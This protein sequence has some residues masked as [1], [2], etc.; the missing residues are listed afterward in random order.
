MLVIIANIV[1]TSDKV[2]S[3]VA[4]KPQSETMDAQEDVVPAELPEHQEDI[5]MDADELVHAVCHVLTAPSYPVQARRDLHNSITAQEKQNAYAK[6]A[7]KDWTF[8]VKRTSIKIGRPP[9]A[10]YPET[11]QGLAQVTPAESNQGLDIPPSATED[12]RVHIDLGPNKVI[13]RLHA[14]IYYQ[15]DHI[16]QQPPGWYLLVNGRNGAKVD[17]TPVRR[18][19]VARLN[20]GC[21]IDIAGLEFMFVLSEGVTIAKPYLQRAG[22]I[23]NDFPDNVDQAR[24]DELLGRPTRSELGN[25]DR[26]LQQAGRQ[27][28]APA[29]ADYRKPDTPQSRQKPARMPSCTPR[30]SGYAFAD[31]DFDLSAP[32]NE[33]IKPTFTYSQLITQ[34][35]LSKPDHKATLF[36]IYEY[37]KAKYAYYRSGERAE[38]GWQVSCSSPC[39]TYNLLT[40]PEFYP[41]QPLS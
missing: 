32:E 3:K 1:Q 9:E 24:H 21:V 18:G 29:P 7:G 6:V 41:T 13:S 15:P 17:E 19:Q 20:S 12:S 5:D 11:E 30:G 8:F 36:H 10:V 33:H 26:P 39:T 22:L 25:F 27:I 35:I 4:E 14:E 34:A 31:V 28:I 16:A 38:K 23:R 37:V 2:I 40:L